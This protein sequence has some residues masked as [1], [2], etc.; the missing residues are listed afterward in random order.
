MLVLRSI[1]VP[2]PLAPAKGA[3]LGGERIATGRV[4]AEGPTDG[5]ECPAAGGKVVM[6]VGLVC[7]S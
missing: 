4:L 5:V 6:A 3:E 1:M 2:A 7:R